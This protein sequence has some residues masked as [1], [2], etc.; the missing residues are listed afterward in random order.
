MEWCEWCLADSGRVQAKRECCRVRMLAKMPQYQRLEAYIK[1][2]GEEGL[3]ARDA[4]HEKV[5]RWKARKLATAPKEVRMKA[6]R[7]EQIEQN[8]Q[9]AERL[10]A[11]VAE[12]YQRLNP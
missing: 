2:A 4:L 8:Q 3:E 5:L 7:M 1:V 10:K 12:E 11:L 6:Y 9:S